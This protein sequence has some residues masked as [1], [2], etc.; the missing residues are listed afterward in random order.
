MSAPVYWFGV[1]FNP[2]VHNVSQWP[3]PVS[4]PRTII[5]EEISKEFIFDTHARSCTHTHTAYTKFSL[6]CLLLMRE[7]ATIQSIRVCI[8]WDRY[9]STTCL[10][11]HP[12]Y[13]TYVVNYMCAFALRAEGLPLYCCRQKCSYECHWAQSAYVCVCVCR[14]SSCVPHAKFA[15]VL[16]KK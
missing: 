16:L 10:C 11:M 2:S 9:E 5:I 8:V 3:F 6:F 1:S 14:I 4:R 7:P 15:C 12:F 13:Y